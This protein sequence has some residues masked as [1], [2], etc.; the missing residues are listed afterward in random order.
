MNEKAPLILIVDDTPKNI[1]VV[2]NLLK[3]QNYRITAA[4]NGREALDVVGKVAPDLILLDIM[5]PEMDGYDVCRNLKQDPLLKDIPVIF[6]TALTESENLVKAFE[7]GGVD[8]IT[9]P[10]NLAELRMR[11]HTHLELKRAR[12]QE[13]KLIAELQQALQEVKFLSGL[14]PICAHCK[15]IRN[16]GGFWEKVENYIQSHS[17]A[18][19]SHGICP[20]CLR[21]LYPDLADEVLASAEKKGTPL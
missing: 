1:Q 13:K 5:M 20:D 16:D 7:V 17:A 14:I 21:K 12:D 2:G 19:F 8:Y 15:N 9:K 11:V 3:D 18:K 10:F 4:Q 6:L